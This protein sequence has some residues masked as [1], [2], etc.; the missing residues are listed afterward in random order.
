M[1]RLAV[2]VLFCLG[3][4]AA[5]QQMPPDFYVGLGVAAASSYFTAEAASLSTEEL[6]VRRPIVN[7]IEIQLRLARDSAAAYLAAIDA[8]LASREIPPAPGMIGLR[9]AP[10]AGPLPPGLEEWPACSGKANDELL[11]ELRR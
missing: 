11:A 6:Q 3:G 7:R 2:L 5:G 9:P 8:Q 4:C 10:P 1:K